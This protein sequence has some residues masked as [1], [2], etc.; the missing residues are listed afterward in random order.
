MLATPGQL[1]VNEALPPEFRDYTRTLG[2]DEIN[3]LLG[4][5]A[6]E[7]PEKYREV[8][9]ALVQLGRNA[10]FDEGSTITLN[11]LVPVIDKQPMLDTV[12][13]E[14]ERIRSNPKL[15]D[16]QK[17]DAIETLYGEATKRLTK[18]TY[19]AA[20]RNN[21]PFAI[22]VKYKARGK[23]SQLG[24][25]LT[26]PGTYTDSEGNL[27]PIF[28]NRS[29]AEGLKPHEYWAASYGARL[30]VTCLTPD[31]KVV[32]G[33]WTEREIG[34]LRPGDV[35]MGAKPDGTIYPVRVKHFFDNGIQPVYRWT[36]RCLSSQAFVDVKATSEHKLLAR[37]RRWG[38]GGKSDPL[39]A[40]QLTKLGAA[41]FG[42]RPDHNSYFAQVSAGGRFTGKHVDTALL[43]GLM[44]GDGCC[45][46]CTRTGMQFSCADLTLLADIKEYLAGFN[47]RLTRTSGPYTHTFSRIDKIPHEWYYSEDGHKFNNRARYEI[48]RYIGGCHSWDKKIPHDIMQ[49]DDESVIAYMAGLF[50]TDGSF[51]RTKSNITSFSLALNSLS[52]VESVKRILELRFGVWCSPVHD[53]QKS[54]VHHMYG[55]AVSHPDSFERLARLMRGVIPGIKRVRLEELHA[56]K[57]SGRTPEIGFRIQSKEYL[58]E[59]HV[60]DIEVDSPDHMFLL[61]NGII[62]SNS[63]KLATQKGG[64]LDKM[65]NAASID[66]VVTE[67]DC[68]TRQGVPFPTDDNDSVGAVLQQEIAGFKPGT[69]ITKHVLDK[70]R[71]S[72]ADEVVV[73]SPMTCAAKDGLCRHC[74]GV[75]E[76][77]RLPDIGY[78]VGINAASA[79]GEQVTQNALNAKHSGKKD[80]LGAYVGFDALKNMTMVPQSYDVKASVANRDGTVT[81]IEQ[82][83]QGGSYV[84]IDND[85]ED[86]IY[87][88][89]S[90]KVQ[91]KSG[92]RVEAGDAVSS[93]LVSPADVVQYKGIGEGRRYFTER[94]RKIFKDSKYGVNRRNVEVLSRALVNN[95]RVDRE[96]SAGSGLP[97]DVL[98][99]STWAGGYSPRE[100]AVV[101]KADKSAL[102]HYL[103]AP[104]LHYTIGTR[105]TPNVLKTLQKH[106]IGDLTTHRDPPGVVP[107]MVSVVEAPAYSGN[108]M[109]RLGT[110]YLKDRLLED[111]QS[112]SSA[113]MH[114]TNPIPA[115]AKGVEFGNDIA[116]KGIY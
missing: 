62:S 3:D 46:D 11:D 12:K 73:R 67:D 4:R 27:I 13:R 18:E 24:A 26:S 68:G 66:Q 53:M 70:I 40:P 30:G 59:Q 101:E 111:V 98:R 87:V 28:I 23:D 41:K 15:T 94:F 93:G 72:G 9:H 80:D 71:A 42:A 21:N 81:A 106:K 83:P 108:W 49:W 31:T 14:A 45:S 38:S 16:E 25:M 34:S 60:V 39:M 75:R 29:Y 47:L 104:V 96:D 64:Y 113:A 84:V 37:V 92:D 88:P 17:D 69:I 79:L 91:V 1:L 61:A 107:H 35:I 43:L 57:T 85:G 22:Q 36:F 116:T 114:S 32:M 109:A 5:L 7:Q 54:R 103:E 33:D 51:Y 105:I 78:N 86:R 65:M 2:Q 10:A 20:L 77:G 110:S 56:S 82:A 76:Q 102:G 55:I 19:A 89:A 50:A 58:G 100:G 44:T 63:T 115:M 112:V 90:L 52:L 48:W 97:G 74:V 8:T 95:V 99:Y 6:R